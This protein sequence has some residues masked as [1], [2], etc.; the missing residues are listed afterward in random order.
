MSEKPTV[1]EIVEEID[2]HRLKWLDAK[3]RAPDFAARARLNRYEEC[4]IQHAP[5][6]ID[7]IR[8]MQEEI[9]QD[10]KAMR[11]AIRAIQSGRE[12]PEVF[13]LALGSAA[14]QVILERRL[15]KHQ[16]KDN[17]AGDADQES[18]AVSG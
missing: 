13:G 14:A 12:K 9:K 6:L 10:K 2:Q 18:S 3:V 15:A 16:P 5:A 7:S 4:L 1:E 8:E 17:G 11:E